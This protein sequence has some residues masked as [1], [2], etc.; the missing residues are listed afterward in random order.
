MSTLIQTLKDNHSD[1]YDKATT[2]VDLQ[3]IH[4]VSDPVLFKLN[5][6]AWAV[7]DTD[8]KRAIHLHG[9]NYQLV[10]YDKI[11]NG[12]SNALDK[13]GITLNNTSIQFTVHPDLNYFKLRILFNDGSKFSPHAMTTNAN[14]KLKFGIEVVSSYD[15]SIVYQV[16]AMFLRLICQNGMKSFESLG[17][18]VKKHTTHF[19]VDDSFLKL[20]HIGTTFEK[21]QDKF[22][23]YNSL[24]LS[25][26]EV[27]S[28]FK[29]FSNGSDN[30][31]NLLKQVLE[32]DIHKSTL[33]DVYN[34]LTNYSSHNKRAIRIG[35]KGSEEYR[36]DNS[37]MD[38][39]RSNEAR[40]SEI[41]KYVSSN[42]FVFF[43]HK[44]LS[45]LGRDVA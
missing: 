4:Y 45:N 17:E 20:Q 30:K 7:V 3:Q 15:A 19:D 9:S 43:Y 10:P 11:L 13:Y 5:K 41:E 26:G 28:I 34:A 8:N 6:P 14:D 42:H 33:Y 40:D 25:S 23:V 44:A 37:S 12:L 1:M 2:E 35:K 32:T 21:M 38:S 27:D 16:R 22:E 29:K 36:I 31:Y 39:I 24:S 18:T